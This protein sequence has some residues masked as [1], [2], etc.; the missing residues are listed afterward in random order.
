MKY[1]DIEKSSKCYHSISGWN[2]E[3]LI[4]SVLI[5]FRLIINQN[6]NN[7][8]VSNLNSQFFEMRSN[9]GSI[10]VDIMTYDNFEFGA[11]PI[12]GNF[13]RQNSS[14][15]KK[16]DYRSCFFGLLLGALLAGGT[17]AVLMW[18]IFDCQSYSSNG[19]LLHCKNW[20]T[21]MC[22]VVL[23]CCL[24]YNLFFQWLTNVFP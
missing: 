18:K 5:L 4:I 20:F 17:A 22:F 13:S 21:F 3:Q 2:I 23:S 24:M 12:P 10:P 7:K 9:K 19:K 16:F 14:K 15:A 1:C 6:I 11:N 8:L